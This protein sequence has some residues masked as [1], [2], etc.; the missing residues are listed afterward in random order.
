MTGSWTANGTGYQKLEYEECQNGTLTSVKQYRC[1]E[2]YYGSSSNGTS[3]CTSCPT[4][5]G[6][7]SVAGDNS[8]I[9][10]CYTPAGTGSD[11]TGSYSIIDKCYY[12]Q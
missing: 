5:T 9:T 6:A 12:Q 10:Q 3:G 7:T 8:A 11:S 1:A 2:G 4:A